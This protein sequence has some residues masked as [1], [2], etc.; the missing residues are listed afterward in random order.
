MRF[1]SPPM[2]RQP[3]CLGEDG[4]AMPVID[5]EHDY[6]D[7]VRAAY[8]ALRPDFA[9]TCSPL[10]SGGLNVGAQIHYQKTQFPA[11]FAAVKTILTYAQYWVW[12][13]TG[14][15][16]NEVTSLGCHTDLWNPQTGELFQPRRHA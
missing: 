2:A 1:R 14:I 11:E 6:P 9:E 10:L 8:A 13:L 5:Y 4:L 3:H 16:V 7:E 12:R 15:A